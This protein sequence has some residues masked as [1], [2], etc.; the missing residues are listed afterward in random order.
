M[1]GV[2][3]AIPDVSAVL[4]RR[5][6]SIVLSGSSIVEGSAD[7]TVLGTASISG[8]FTG[9]AAWS[10]SDPT[11]TF[12]INSSTGV[13]TVLSNTDLV[14]ATHPFIPIA[15]SVSGVTPAVPAANVSVSV[16]S[17]VVAYLLSLFDLSDLRNLLKV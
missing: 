1:P 10:L 16:L 7:G 15:V 3:L 4:F 2:S 13:V 17:A 8:P 11:G 9:T 5:G 14:H 12:E 6:D